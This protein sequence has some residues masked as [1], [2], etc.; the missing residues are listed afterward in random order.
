M[1]QSLNTH[2]YGGYEALCGWVYCAIKRFSQWRIVAM[3]R[4]DDNLSNHSRLPTIHSAGFCCQ[5]QPARLVRRRSAGQCVYEVKLQ[6]P[7][8]AQLW[9]DSV[10]VPVWGVM[11]IFWWSYCSKQLF[12]YGFAPVSL[13]V[14]SLPVVQCSEVLARENWV[15]DPFQCSRTKAMG[16]DK[17]LT[18]L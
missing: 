1:L 7:Y 18:D 13:D 6:W 14:K 10:L 8:M 11:L 3:Q 17:S 4:C 9:L 5:N 15:V 2:V 12:S 16:F